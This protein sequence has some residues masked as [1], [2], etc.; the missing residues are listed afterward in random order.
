MGHPFLFLTGMSLFLS[1]VISRLVFIVSA[2]VEVYRVARRYN[3]GIPVHSVELLTRHGYARAARRFLRKPSDG[4][5]SFHSF[6]L[7][8]ALSS[9]NTPDQWKTVVGPYVE[10]LSQRE[11]DDRRSLLRL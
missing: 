6:P 4:L 1:V 7:G 10:M 11:N 3:A 5:F 9:D 2:L 8:E